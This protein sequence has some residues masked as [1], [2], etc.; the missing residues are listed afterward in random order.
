MSQIYVCIHFWR[1]W[2]IVWWLTVLIL[3]PQLIRWCVCECVLW[4][5]NRLKTLCLCAVFS[6]VDD[7]C[8]YICITFLLCRAPARAF[9]FT[10]R[11]RVLFSFIGRTLNAFLSQ[12]NDAFKS[13]LMCPFSIE[14]SHSDLELRNI[15]QCLE[16]DRVS[17][18]FEIFFLH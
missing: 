16:S 1:H 14:I 17:E 11:E 6:N 8:I 12:A 2:M 4:C 15:G 18:C 3:L 7:L 9:T 13:I 10:P 5:G